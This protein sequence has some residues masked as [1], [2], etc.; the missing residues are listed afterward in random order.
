MSNPRGFFNK[1]ENNID[2]QAVAKKTATD[3]VVTID[4]VIAREDYEK[5]LEEAKAMAFGI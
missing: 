2:Q 5:Q 3:V 4:K 1:K